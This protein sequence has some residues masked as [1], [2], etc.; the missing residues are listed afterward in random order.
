MAQAV[1][2]IPMDEMLKLRFNTFCEN[3]GM[4][5]AVAVNMFVTA[6]LRDK[7]IP[8]DI[9]ADDDPFYSAKNQA[10]LLEAIAQMEAGEGLIV[11]TMEE[12]E[13][14]ENE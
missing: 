5:T 14:M 13:A 11:K 10:V 3:A 1:L 12:L 9:T 2:S 8:F 7:R 6:V 4:D